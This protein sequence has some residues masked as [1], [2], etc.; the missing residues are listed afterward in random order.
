MQC[1]PHQLAAVLLESCVLHISA[2]VLHVD[3]NS[4]NPTPPCTN[5]LTAAANIQDAVDTANSS[6]RFS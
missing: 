3:L 4:T 2:A 6:A 5:W 1:R